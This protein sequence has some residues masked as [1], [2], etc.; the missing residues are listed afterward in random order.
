MKKIIISILLIINVFIYAN[1]DINS[2][3]DNFH[4]FVGIY[5][6]EFNT[7]K[8]LISTNVTKNFTPAS[9]TKLFTLFSAYEI[10]GL[11][12]TYK[13]K[14]YYENGD[15][16]VKGSGDPT[17]YPA[18]LHNIIKTLVEENNITEINNIIIDDRLFD[19]KEFFGK[20]WMWD[21]ANPF[22]NAFTIKNIRPGN[23]SPEDI[24]E[25]MFNI[26]KKSFEDLNVK[27]NG[28]LKMKYISS[29]KVPFYIHKSKT[30]YEI[31]QYMVKNSDNEIAEHIFRTV[32]TKFLKKGTINNSIAALI[33]LTKKLF[34]YGIN[35]FTIVDGPGLSRYNLVSPDLVVQMLEFMYKK[36]G[37]KFLNILSYSK[38]DGTINGRFN[39]DVW[40]KTGTM[41]GISGIAGFLKNKNGKIIVFSLF[42]NN[43]LKAK[44]DA[45][46]FENRILEF[47]YN[48][49]E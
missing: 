33:N 42:E 17:L 34:N 37:D 45:K 24:N 4:G 16:E 13:T 19:K 26:I 28:E 43:Y 12:Y 23:L 25:Y 49:S 35:D 36:Y 8:I 2:I 31:L 11:D 15:F 21:D 5:A 22:I 41:T 39:F 7:N 30:L 46:S 47:L 32:G 9:V 38:A 29:K 44:V 3:I 20:G 6:K 10:L 48:Y 18:D 40:A 14:F 1:N 27:V